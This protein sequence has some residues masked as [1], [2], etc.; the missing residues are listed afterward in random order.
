MSRSPEASFSSSTLLCSISTFHLHLNK[1]PKERCCPPPLITTFQKMTSTP[2][3][4]PTSPVL[5]RP[6]LL[7]CL[8]MMMISFVVAFPIGASSATVVESKVHQLKNR[9][10]KCW[11]LTCSIIPLSQ[12]ISRRM[13]TSSVAVVQAK[14]F[15]RGCII[16]ANS[17]KC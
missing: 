9:L 7:T 12:L 4:S 13:R 5:R 3:L 8:L 6:Q 14:G 15:L 16:V 17:S 10:S 11:L 1:N 2:P